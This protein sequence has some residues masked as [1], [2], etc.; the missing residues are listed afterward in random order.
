MLTLRSAP[1]RRLVTALTSVA[2]AVVAISTAFA[3]VAQSRARA[4]VA[5]TRD[6]QET[7]REVVLSVVDAETA[8]RGYLL[9]E[10]R[11]HLD[12][13]AAA[14]SRIADAQQRL[15]RLTADNPRQ[16]PR[17]AR[18]Q[19]NTTA[20]VE[21]LKQTLELH[22][23]GDT[24]SMTALVISGEGKRRMDSVRAI[25]NE[26]E[27]EEEALLA[28]RRQ[29]EAGASRLVLGVLL[30]GSLLAIVLT[31]VIGR[32][33]NLAVT[34]EESLNEELAHT[35]L[36]LETSTKE[37][38]SRND[39]LELTTEELEATNEELQQANDAYAATNSQ[40][41]D[42]RQTV[43]INRRM[44]QGVVDGTPDSVFLKD[45][46]LRYILVNEAAARVLGGTPAQVLGKTDQELFPPDV[47]AWLAPQDQAIMSSGVTRVV[48]ELVHV[49][50]IP[51]YYLTTKSPW[52]DEKGKVVGLIGIAR[53]IT[54]RREMETR[55]R[56]V[57]RL[58]G[59]GRLA[60]GVAH[61][62]NNQMTIILGCVSFLLRRDDLAESAREDAR[63][64]RH[65]AERASLI[66]SQL[67]A[68]S[69][70]QM[71]QTQIV[72]VNQLLERFAPVLRRALTESHELQ[73][74]LGAEVGQV[75]VDPGQIEQALLNVVLNAVDAMPD[76]G[77]ITMSSGR[78]TLDERYLQMKPE[79]AVRAGPY[80]TI[81]VSDTGHGMDAEVLSHAFDP[82][83][84]TK[85]VGKGTGLGLSSVYGIVKQSGGYVWLYSEPGRGTVVKLY[86][87]L[88]PTA[89]AA[90]NGAG[91]AAPAAAPAG[92]LAERILV[93]ED[94]PMVRQLSVRTLQELGYTVMEAANGGEALAMVTRDPVSLNLVVTDVAMP[95]MDGH[96]LAR[97]IAAIRP[98]L[99]VLAM[100]G[101]TDDDVVRRGL[102]DPSVPFLQKP[103]SPETLAARVRELVSNPRG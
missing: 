100:S 11:E 89:V 27:A 58:E 103:F 46:A 85:A 63:A 57:G 43:E 15:A 60:G 32:A 48:E 34:R 80:A 47:V 4:A 20:K 28:M 97:Q 69:R 19:A 51:R 26:I 5:H 75:A 41:E 25:A 1:H 93:V 6:V 66:T 42:A 35:L 86:L 94:D 95:G 8:Q 21:E 18:L 30:V 10:R 74:A 2:I 78:V 59:I 98:S 79:V 53:D 36:T 67:L 72:D 64:I 56:Q 3:F 90:T 96:E 82:F 83:F 73:L 29:A 62:V 49:D 88:A 91:A 24:A 99:P 9:T 31:T 52:R 102:L 55:L 65:A 22:R 54:E 45:R 68:F 16:T 12:P 39:E 77:V 50:G 84:T 61:E 38:A 17:L 76:G 13:Y 81:I 101:Y 14:V 23:R 33:M 71:L 92:T 70:Q 40:L 44:L 87:P 7:I 37:V